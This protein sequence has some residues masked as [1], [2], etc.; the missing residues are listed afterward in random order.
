MTGKQYGLEEETTYPR[1]AIKGTD[2]KERRLLKTAENETSH[3]TVPF[4]VK[5]ILAQVRVL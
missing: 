5:S 2:L 3:K 4:S 1:A